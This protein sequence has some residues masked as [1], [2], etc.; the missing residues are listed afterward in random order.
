MDPK[1]GNQKRK[2]EE[3]GVGWLG[4][5]VWSEGVGFSCVGDGRGN[6]GNDKLASSV[7]I[8]K[9]IRRFCSPRCQRKQ[10]IFLLYSCIQIQE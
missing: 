3:T 1:E 8:R 2:V 7:S 6:T 10:K 9:R 4:A 5:T